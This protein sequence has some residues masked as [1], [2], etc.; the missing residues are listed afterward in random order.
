MR[1]TEICESFWHC[2]HSKIRWIGVR[3]FTPLKWR[4]DASI[5]QRT[6]RIGRGRGPIL[7]ILV[8]I[9]E[10]TVPLFLPPLRT[11]Q[12]GYAPLDCTRQGKR[13]TP[14]LAEAPTRFD[15]HVHMHPS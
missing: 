6:Y 5:R 7:R 12:S 4:R 1:I 10:D 2:E 3:H 13:C 8:V 11:R 14:N 9:E 15:T